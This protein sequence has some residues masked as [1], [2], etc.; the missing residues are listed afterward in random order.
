MQAALVEGRRVDGDVSV[1]DGVI[2]AVGLRPTGRRGIAVPGFVDVHVNGFGGVDFLTAGP[3][4]LRR[5]AVALAATGVVAFQPTFVSAP[6]PDL[7]AA[8]DTIRAL[9]GAPGAQSLGVHL[10]GP[11]ISPRWAGAHDPSSLLAPD[12]RLARELCDA[13]PVATVT[14]APELPGGLELVELLAGRGVTVSLGHSDADAATAHAA[15]DRGARAIT[16]I[17][18]AHRR[19]APRDPGLAGAALVRSDVTVQAI[20]DGVHLAPETAFATYLAAR[21]RFCLVTDAI[22]AA[23]LGPGEY[24]LGG[25]RLLVD[26]TSARLADGT[27]AGSI[28]TIDAAVRRLVDAGAP[29]AEAVRAASGTPARLLR[30]ADLGVLRPGMPA[31]VAVL[32]EDLRVLRTLVR[33]VEVHAAADPPG[34]P[35]AR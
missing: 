15:F 21:E 4:E 7:R 18:N 12:P 33:G 2:A 23:G 10:E 24:R 11:F 1:A 16:H 31:N 6:P 30:R 27:L 32:D 8:L 29:L 19:W 9:E 25:R 20:L 35:P 17:H 34:R 26:G 28:L 5:A 3:D 14:L 22:E 13:G